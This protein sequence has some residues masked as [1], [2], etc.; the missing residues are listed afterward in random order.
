MEMLGRSI[1]EN[2]TLPV[3]GAEYQAGAAVPAAPSRDGK[4]GSLIELE[5]GFRAAA[6]STSRWN[7]AAVSRRSVD[8]DDF[9]RKL[10]GRGCHFEN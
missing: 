4:A 6:A 10:I 7:A 8:G 1:G 3:T 9:S 5:S 2:L